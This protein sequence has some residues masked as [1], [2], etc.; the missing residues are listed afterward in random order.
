MTTSHDF[1]PHKTVNIPGT[2]HVLDFE[3][4]RDGRLLRLCGGG[5]DYVVATGTKRVFDGGFAEFEELFAA[6]VLLRRVNVNGRHWTEHYR[7]D[8]QA[9][10]TEVDGMIIARD[11]EGRVVECAGHGQHWIYTYENGVLARMDGPEHS[12]RLSYDANQRPTGV[13]FGDKQELLE[14][15]GNGLRQG[16]KQA[17]R[18]WHR[19]EE[20]R[21]WAVS[22]EDGKIIATYLWDEFACLARIDGAPGAAIAEVYSLDIG[23]TPVRVST[24]D[25]TTIIPRDL[26]GI[27]LTRH[28]GV[29]GLFGGAQHEGRVFY[30]MRSFDPLPG[31]FNAP[32]PLDGSERD[33]RRDDGYIG[34]L[35]AERLTAGGY[36]ICGYDTLT[37]ADPTGGIAW[38]YMLSTLTWAFPNNWAL[39]LGLDWTI[40][41]WGSLF[42]GRMGRFFN[43]RHISS[44][45]LNMGGVLR[46]GAMGLERAF[47]TQHYIWSSFEE[48]DHTREVTVCSPNDRFQPG[49][50]GT[51]L[52][53]VESST[54][55]AFMLRGMRTYAS[56]GLVSPDYPS[57]WTRHGGEAERIA[58]GMLRPF[59]PN[60]GLHLGINWINNQPDR[61]HGPT[62]AVLTEL[63][64][65]DRFATGIVEDLAVI[66]V[67]RTDVDLEDN[68]RIGLADATDAAFIATVHSF[69]EQG[70]STTIRLNPAPTGIANNGLR[71]APL[72]QATTTEVLNIVPDLRRMDVQGSTGAYAVD[73]Y[74]QMRQGPDDRGS[75][76]ITGLE[77]RVNLDDNFNAAPGPAP[78]AEVF[79]AVAGGP[80][81]GAELTASPLELTFPNDP[82]PGL[83]DMIRVFNGVDDIPV[84]ITAVNGNDRT[85]DRGLGALGGAGTAVS[86]QAL[87]GGGALGTAA[88]FDVAAQLTYTSVSV[89]QALSAG[90][91][92]IRTRTNEVQVRRVTGL[93]YDA[94]VLGEDRTGNAA[95]YDVEL[96]KPTDPRLTN[97]TLGN[98]VVL[99]LDNAMQT[100]DVVALQ[101]HQLANDAATGNHAAAA[102]VRDLTLAGTVL[103]GPVAAIGGLELRPA[104]AVGLNDGANQEIN[105]IRFVERHVPLDRDLPIS[106]GG[107][108]AIELEAAGI[109]YNAERIDDTIITVLPTDAGTNSRLEMPRF[110]AG[111]LVEVSYVDALANINDQFRIQAVDGMELTLEGGRGV[112]PGTGSDFAVQ[113]LDVHDPENGGFNVAIEGEPQ[114]ANADGTTRN[115]R[116]RLWNWRDL[117]GTE[118]IGIVVGDRTLPARVGQTRYECTQPNPANLEE[119]DVSNTIGGTVVSQPVFNIG[120]RV[121]VSWDPGGGAT[122]D[123]FNITAVSGNVVTLV[124]DSGVPV[125]TTASTNITIRRLIV[126]RVG[127]ATPPTTVVGTIDIEALLH[128]GDNAWAATYRA[129]TDTTI[130]LDPAVTGSLT[131]GNRQTV[132]IPLRETAVQ[133]DAVM[134][135]GSVLVPADPENWEH[136]RYQSLVEHELRHTEQ[137]LWWGPMWFCWLPLWA[138]DAGFS[139]RHDVDLP[140]WS[141]FISATIEIDPVDEAVRLVRIPNREG[142]EFKEDSHVQLF[143]GSQRENTKFVQKRADDLY[144]LKFS[145]SGQ[146]RMS[147]GP[148]YLRKLNSDLSSGWQTTYDVFYEMFELTTLGGITDLLF[149][150]GY[151]SMMFL[152]ARLPWIIYKACSNY[153]RYPGTVLA[154]RNEIQLTES[155]RRS[156]FVN[157]SRIVIKQ[158]GKEDFVR[159]LSSVDEAG[160]LTLGSSLNFNG[161][162]EVSPY[163]SNLA[164]ARWYWQD[165]HPATLKPGTFAIITAQEEDGKKLS[166]APFDRLYIIGE[167][168]NNHERFT[169]NSVVTAVNGD[170]IELSD[171]LPTDALGGSDQVL[172]VAKIGRQTSQGHV[173]RALYDDASFMGPMRWVSDPLRQVHIRQ[174]DNQRSGWEIFSRIA[175]YIWGTHNWST[176]P[177]AFGWVFWDRLFPDDAQAYLSNIEQDASYQSGDLYSALGRMRGTVD[178]GDQFA[179]TMVVGD[180][181]RYWFWSEVRDRDFPSNG[182]FTQDAPGVNTRQRVCVMPFITAETGAAAPGNGA[183][184]NN[185]AEA[186]AVATQPGLAVPDV[187]YAKNTA[188]PVDAPA[189]AAGT[190]RRFMPTDRGWIPTSKTL[191]RTQGMYVAFTTPTTGNDRHRVTTDNGIVSGNQARHAQDE[192]QA[193]ILY[194]VNVTDITVTLNG[195]AITEGMTINLLKTQRARFVCQPNNNR[196]YRATVLRPTNGRVVRRTDELEIE[197]QSDTPLAPL[198]AGTA[199]AV[200]ISRYYRWDAPNGR[201]ETGSLTQ[202]GMHLPT[203]IDI[204]VRRITVN[205]EDTPIVLGALNTPVDFNSYGTAVPD[206]TPGG[207]VFVF[208]AANVLNF[209]PQITYPGTAGTIHPV[210]IQQDQTADAPAATRNFLGAGGDIGGV[211]RLS[212]ASDDPP[213]EEA[214][215]TVDV[216]VGAT[217]NLDDLAQVVIPITGHFLATSG[218]YSAGAGG[219]ITLD[220]AN[221]GGGGVT[222]DPNNVVVTMPDGTPPPEVSPGTP[223]LT[224]AA[225]GANQLVVNV[226]AGFSNPGTRRLLIRE[227]GN[228][229]NV[230]RRTITLT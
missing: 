209:N 226:D 160:K 218:S 88:T 203:D 182:G 230:A 129:E 128:T 205:V 197:I 101:V 111:E 18:N 165:Y 219:S 35:I 40:N 58:P 171:P 84:V 21:L 77:A 70:G 72:Q 61:V 94:I 139:Y 150:V 176:F 227:N 22:D 174:V 33:P 27:N 47:T 208:I 3:Y 149:S 25:T 168:N 54:N 211:F 207:E 202:H 130:V 30:A 79:P 64:T 112:L 107:L 221:V 73:D 53:L 152:V 36:G 69:V 147:A 43:F 140:K 19:D 24:A 164:S 161:P 190:P 217:G 193:K 131:A 215:V 10:P 99:A 117:R 90:Y 206:L 180:I 229:S 135:P 67:G 74:I 39:T 177:P 188:A 83:G 169:M 138:M 156:E 148:I 32:D 93:E 9:I 137:Y 151:G 42:S 52:R 195:I 15:D 162:V 5:R 41:F 212:I 95:P 82:R 51:V 34:N 225:G 132:V 100:D 157:E 166:A 108:R 105:L 89:R 179:A 110:F 213:E 97:V 127:L 106:A 37:F 187:F 1:N 57:A 210:L 220:C 113:R 196:R 204:A 16:V 104:Q 7:W 121:E 8:E 23:G 126:L 62:N 4:D 114:V 125:I 172:R 185:N 65:M 44:E 214:Q 146:P 144:R 136:D 145:S 81:R 68:T 119:L 223:E 201:F 60:G 2:D 20:G 175:R 63:E 170:D 116:F 92:A 124:H 184:P 228:A 38:Y 71:L 123:E 120:E 154:S 167:K 153:T 59:F 122:T 143:R 14:Y 80:V 115:I 29:P 186:G 198:A 200:E 103:S 6:G 173:E 76:L 183:E 178:V 31:L 155:G 66:T 13:S 28:K 26:F 78:G 192:N 96:F 17:P 86:W 118:L 199:E 11:G 189:P 102:T 142:I 45:R 163:E 158:S 191:G 109:N 91:L 194:N 56:D 133:T 98:A 134:H 55:R 46:D 216:Q 75:R 48:W 181:A 159:S 49:M 12:L 87:V 222:P 85:V 141:K 50:Y 224:F